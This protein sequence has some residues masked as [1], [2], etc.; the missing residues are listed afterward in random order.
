MYQIFCLMLL[1]SE[2]G[3][4][5]QSL[6]NAG[7]PSMED[8]P[9]LSIIRCVLENILTN[10]RLCIHAKQIIGTP[11]FTNEDKN[12]PVILISSDSVPVS[13]NKLKMP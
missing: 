7:V 4:A 5:V 1:Q 2:S 9:S 12:D 6:L 8:K 10:M 3:C 11:P 13:L